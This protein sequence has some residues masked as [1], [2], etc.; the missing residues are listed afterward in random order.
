MGRATRGVAGRLLAQDAAAPCIWLSTSVNS[1][2]SSDPVAF[3]VTLSAK[4]SSIDCQLLR[5]RY[6]STPASFSAWSSCGCSF[7]IFASQTMR[8]WSALLS[9]CGDANCA[10]VSHMISAQLASLRCATAVW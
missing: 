2:A 7:K 4:A 6:W 1:A 10:C 5:Q 8:A 3:T 9:H